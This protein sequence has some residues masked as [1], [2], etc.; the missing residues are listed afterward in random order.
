MS[1]SKT[2][3]IICNN[4]YNTTIYVFRNLCILHILRLMG[5]GYFLT[6]FCS[7]IKSKIYLYLQKLPIEQL[8]FLYYLKVTFPEKIQ[9]TPYRQK[10]NQK[11]IKSFSN[12]WP[13]SPAPNGLS[14]KCDYICI[15]H[16][17]VQKGEFGFI[18]YLSAIYKM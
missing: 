3:C 14:V 6:V 15:N 4:I 12:L 8:N 2:M 16:F 5:Q 18:Q 11:S 1:L 13:N 10:V 17:S 7:F 9:N